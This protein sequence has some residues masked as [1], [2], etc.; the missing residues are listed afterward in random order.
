M[1]V[2]QAV[3]AAAPW[4]IVGGISAATAGAIIASP[5]IAEWVVGGVI[6]VWTAL[7]IVRV[8]MLAGMARL[9]HNSL[10]AL[11]QTQPAA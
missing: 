6:T 2:Q 11:P 9:L 1:T 8:M 4:L 10:A 7:A 5:E 3:R